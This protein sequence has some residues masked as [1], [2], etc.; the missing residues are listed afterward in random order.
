MSQTETLLLFVLGFAVAM[1]LALFFGRLAWRLALRLGARR[2]RQQVPSTV[3][4]L[5]ADRDRLRADYAVLSQRLG[6][7]LENVKARMAEQMAEVTR[8]RNRVQSLAADVA[9]RDKTIGD[10]E[11]LIA[12]RDAEI[13]AL[14]DRVA[15]LELELAEA[16]AAASHDE[17]APAIARAIASVDT[18]I[19]ASLQQRIQRLAEL[20]SE[21][22]E[23]QK[24]GAAAPDETATPLLPE[25]LDEKLL[26]VERET[27]ELQKEL[28][29]LDVAR[30]SAEAPGDDG[31]EAGGK[32]PAG[33]NVISLA[34]HVP[35]LQK[36]AAK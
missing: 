10:R 19:A 32:P 13:A 6:S 21:I 35:A 23:N 11:M 4:E 5:Q 31:T 7:H 15:A 12:G 25:D 29:R 16:R 18:L 2:M 33:D 9:V 36:D 24:Q 28:A 30:A 27:A 22:A 3:R 34:G 14:R 20:S 17:G 1:L 8:N 26:Q